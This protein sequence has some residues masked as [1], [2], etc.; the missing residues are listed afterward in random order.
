MSRFWRNWLM[1]WCWSV[2]LFG[3]V[4]AAA[5]FEAT[6]GPCRLLFH[7]LNRSSPLELGDQMRFALAVMGAVTIGWSFTLMAAIQ[8]AHLLGE[9]GGAVW[10]LT[11]LGVVTWFVV[12]SS[13]SVATGYGLNA[14]PNTILLLAFL[15]PVI[16]GGV[17]RP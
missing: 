9:R 15:A 14:V 5:A 7:L 2:A 1:A 4:L 3:V 17:L 8:A 6:S 16:R 12:D 13:L 11:T 10:R